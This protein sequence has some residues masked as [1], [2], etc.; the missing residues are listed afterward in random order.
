M[1]TDINWAIEDMFLADHELPV[2][3]NPLLKLVRWHSGEIIPNRCQKGSMSDVNH[4]K[5]EN[6]TDMMLI[7][8][9]SCS[10]ARNMILILSDRILRDLL[11]Y[12]RALNP[13]G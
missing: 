5:L 4:N 11:V 13:G 10:A 6:D 1:L 12:S 2:T 8:R 7:T 9:P 3:S